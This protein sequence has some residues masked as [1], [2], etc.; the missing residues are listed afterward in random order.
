MIKLVL[1]DI[2]GTL[3]DTDAALIRAFQNVFSCF[4]MRPPTEQEVLQGVGHCDEEWIKLAWTGSCPIPTQKVAEMSEYFKQK[5]LGFYFPVLARLGEGAKETLEKLRKQGIKTAIV[6][7]GRKEYA[8]SVL[9]YFKLEGL[10]DL[11]VSA[12]DVAHVKPS[13]E[14]LL[15]ALDHFKLKPWDALYLGDTELDARAAKA[16][17]V[18]FALMVRARNSLVKSKRRL[19]SLKEIPVLVQ[20]L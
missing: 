5:Y 11:V 7:N 8:E 6:T 1:F 19:G 18:H 15:H 12:D 14:P 2:D 10:F 9:S 16:A 20:K 3:I 13:P 4:A 17:K